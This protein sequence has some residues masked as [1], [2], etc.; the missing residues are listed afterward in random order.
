LRYTFLVE[1]GKG[2]QP[3][4]LVFSDRPLQVLGAIWILLFAVGVY[5]S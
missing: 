1:K 2:A 4:E 3:E 5:A